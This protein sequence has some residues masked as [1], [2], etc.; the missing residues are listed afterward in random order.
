MWQYQ[1]IAFA[2]LKPVTDNSTSEKWG[3]SSAGSTVLALSDS[4][5][6]DFVMTGDGNLLSNF[7][8]KTSRF[9]FLS[10]IVVCVGPSIAPQT[11]GKSQGRGSF[12]LSPQAL[13]LTYT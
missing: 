11:G 7:L 10:L 1:A 4:Y 3:K 8:V 13:C 12:H 9:I 5:L 2:R 6:K